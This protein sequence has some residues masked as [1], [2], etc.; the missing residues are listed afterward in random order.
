M[1][2]H[3][4]ISFYLCTNSR[5]LDFHFD[6]VID[7]HDECK[8]VCFPQSSSLSYSSFSALLSPLPI[9]S[10]HPLSSPAPHLILSHSLPLFLFSPPPCL[11]S[12]IYTHTFQFFKSTYIEKLSGE[13]NPK[14]KFFKVLGFLNGWEMFHFHHVCIHGGADGVFVGMEGIDNSW[15]DKERSINNRIISPAEF[16]KYAKTRGLVPF[17]LK[18]VNTALGQW[19]TTMHLGSTWYQN[20][21]HQRSSSANPAHWLMKLGSWYEIAL[22]QSD[23]NKT[24]IFAQVSFVS[25][26]YFS[27]FLFSRLYLSICLPIYISVCLFCSCISVFL[28]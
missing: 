4:A 6:H 11:N 18:R 24:N 12:Q 25:F 17:M 22:C 23:Y 7:R 26:L 8:I 3:C 2:T 19:N 16:H 13:W 1:F 10:V 21:F 14:K 27:Y 28:L 5:E 9:H 15:A 20:C